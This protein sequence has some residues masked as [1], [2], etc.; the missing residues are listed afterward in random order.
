MHVALEAAQPAE[1]LGPGPLSG[2]AGAESIASGV[3]LQPSV[4]PK[5]C[6]S[7]KSST[8]TPESR[9]KVRGSQAGGGKHHSLLQV[10][11]I[12]AKGGWS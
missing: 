9:G 4:K 5:A 3:L 2:W 8:N 6:S 1:L 10:L 11:G 7:S 12:A